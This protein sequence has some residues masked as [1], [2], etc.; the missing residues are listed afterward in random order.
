MRVRKSFTSF[1]SKLPWKSMVSV[2]GSW[3]RRVFSVGWFS[4][5]SRADRDEELLKAVLETSRAQSEAVAQIAKA[6]ASY[7]DSFKVN[8][9]PEA[10][11]HADITQWQK[12]A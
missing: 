12:E 3:T 6:F 9:A 4:K 5:R 7:L 11:E 2:V 1:A 10:R 8:G